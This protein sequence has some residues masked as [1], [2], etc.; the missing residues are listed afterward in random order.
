[1]MKK[2]GKVLAVLLTTWIL[3]F[4]STVSGWADVSGTLPDIDTDKPLSLTVICSYTDEQ[5]VTLLDGATVVICKVA[6]VKVAN[7]A[8][9]YTLAD[10][11]T[12]SG[13]T[14]DNMTAS[15]SNEA[16]KKFAEIAAAGNIDTVTG[17]TDGEG[18]VVFNNLEAG[19]YLVRET[20]A[21]GTAAKYSKFDPYL[22]MLPAAETSQSG[23]TWT[24][25]EISYP[26]T[27]VT[28]TSQPDNGGNTPNGGHSSHDHT[29]D[30]DRPST[31][32]SAN[33]TEPEVVSVETSP[34][35]HDV[36]PADMTEIIR[37]IVKTGDESHVLLYGAICLLALSGLVVY[38]VVRKRYKK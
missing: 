4:S 22:V 30:Y 5:T 34:E 29:P 14:F 35:V 10:G 8:A 17:I 7:G 20:D 36:P 37:K 31:G 2:M 9:E 27:T 15:E 28:K 19:I 38:V 25:E 12:E 16:A 24:Y 32:T 33:P 21:S 3:A 18:K 6:D 1:M 26:K 13:V 23:T 11:F